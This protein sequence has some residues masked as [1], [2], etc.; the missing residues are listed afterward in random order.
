MYAVSLETGAISLVRGDGR[1]GRLAVAVAD[2]RVVAVARNTDT[3]QVVVAA[4]DAA[5]GERPWPALA[6]QANSAPGPRPRR[7]AVAVRRFGRPAVRAL[8]AADGTERWATLA[9]SLFSPA[10]ALAFDD[11]SVFA[12]DIAGGLYRLEPP[13][14]GARGA[15]SSTRS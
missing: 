15:T 5:T 14:A 1:A 9:L 3:A 7:A 2:G 10:T 6:I 12:A 4:F 11:Q 13:T 8:D